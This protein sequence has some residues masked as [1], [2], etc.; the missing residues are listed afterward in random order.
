MHKVD[1]RTSQNV[2]DATKQLLAPYKDTV[3]TITADN[4][5]EFTDH[6]SASKALDSEF[7]FAHAYA[8]WERGLNENT[9]GL[10]RQYF[11]KKSS[12]AAITADDIDLVMERLK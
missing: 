2:S 8:S 7:Y 5:K 3:L 9:N 11:P 10:V 1:R 6:I 12:F 4:G